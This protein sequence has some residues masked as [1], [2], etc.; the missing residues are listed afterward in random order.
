ML[1][2][3]KALKPKYNFSGITTTQTTIIGDYTVMMQSNICNSCCSQQ[4]TE[5][6]LVT[7]HLETALLLEQQ[8]LLPL[9][10]S[11]V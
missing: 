11:F 7:C 8:V 4:Y 10:T 9:R 1:R 2:Q 3:A 5:A 6:G